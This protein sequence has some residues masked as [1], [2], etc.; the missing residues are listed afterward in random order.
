MALLETSTKIFAIAALWAA[1]IFFGAV[2]IR[3]WRARELSR[4]RAWA[5]EDAIDAAQEFDVEDLASHGWLRRWLYLAGFRKVS[6]PSMFLAITGACALVGILLAV[7]VVQTGLTANAVAA[8]SEVPGG[9]A[10]LAR[11]ILTGA[12]WILV[13]LF[14]LLPL[15]IVSNTRKRRIAEIEQDMPVTLELLATMSESGLAF[16]SALDRVIGSS[17]TE[18]PLFRELRS[19]Q[20]ET[21]GGVPR[22]QCFRR[23]ARR[24]EVPSVSVFVSALVQAEQIGS[25]FTK[26]LRTQADDLRNRRREDANML[27]QALTV[28][29]VF[30]L[31]LCFLPG[32]FVCTLGPTFLQFIK[33]TDSLSQG[34]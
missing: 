34:Q 16:D 23:L 9:V 33:L 20:L 25:G 17:A 5:E 22:V 29:L 1:A 19:F 28:K 2:I 12:P 13:G 4:R 15:T 32:I 11:P 10:D 8:A 14:V 26:V 3:R 21:L 7:V 18:R 27:A 24:I 31:V 30:P 6:A